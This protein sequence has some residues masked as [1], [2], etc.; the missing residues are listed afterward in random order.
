W[1]GLFFCYSFGRRKGGTGAILGA[2][3]EDLQKP[4]SKIWLSF[5]VTAIL[6]GAL[7]RLS[8]PADIEYKGD[9]KYMFEATQDYRATGTLPLLGMK[10]GIKLKNPGMS[11]WVFDV[12]SKISGASNPP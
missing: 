11:I 3:F 5:L 1:L 10:S 4:N 8:F 2:M 9:E 7:L 6:L 12:L